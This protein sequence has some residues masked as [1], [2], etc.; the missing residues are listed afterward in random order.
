[1][2]DPVLLFIMVYLFA[3]YTVMILVNLWV[4]F[5]F[6][7][8]VVD[9]VVGHKLEAHTEKKRRTRLKIVPNEKKRH[10]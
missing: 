10:E 5:A 3:I 9:G 6:T 1:M 4:L 7:V 2:P 8:L